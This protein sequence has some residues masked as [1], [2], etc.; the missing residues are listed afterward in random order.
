LTTGLTLATAVL[1]ALAAP[2]IA[3]LYGQQF[4]KAAIVIRVMCA[5]SVL[6]AINISAGQIIWSLDAAR[7]AMLF[8]LLQGTVLVG[9]SFLLAGHGAEGLAWAHL[10]TA[11][12]LTLAQVP[13]GVLRIRKVL[14]RDI[15]P[16]SST[17]ETVRI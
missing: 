4:G 8:A 2:Y 13:F 11:A 7:A 12:V 15:R 3:S 9:A 1:V 14:P 17:A 16:V 5:C 6:I 10:I